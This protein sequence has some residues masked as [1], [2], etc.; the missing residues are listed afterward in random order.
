MRVFNKANQAIGEQPRA[1]A[2][3]V[4]SRREP[5]RRMRRLRSGHC[6]GS[7][8][9]M[10][11]WGSSRT[12]SDCRPPPHV[13]AVVTS[14]ARAVTPDIAAAWDEVYWLFGCQ[15][16]AEEAKLYALG[17][18]DPER[19]WRST[20]RRATRRE[21]GN[22]LADPRARWGKT[23]NITRASTSRSPSTCSGESRQPRQYTISSDPAATRSGL[24]SS[25]CPW[26]RRAPDG[27]VSNWFGETTPNPAPFWMSRSPAVI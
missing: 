5:H 6:A 3:V 21:P 2:S 12:V 10:C 18:T 8:I 7:P 17:G 16:I 14:S 1:A 20:G 15:L 9:S 23:P 22:F 26:R 27:Q 13:W 11:H 24:P 4:A 19:P 25:V